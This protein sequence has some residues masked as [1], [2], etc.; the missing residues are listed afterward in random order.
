MN[1]RT[2][3]TTAMALLALAALLT[4]GTVS[5]A[6]GN[7][8][9]QGD[10][11]QQQ[12]TIEALIA[13]RFTQTAAVQQSSGA[14]LTAEAATL[15]APTL[16]AQFEATVEAAFNQALTATAGPQ[17]TATAQAEAQVRDQ[18]IAWESGIA[19]AVIA[20]ISGVLTARQADVVALAA[21]GRE[22]FTSVLDL[23][24]SDAAFADR[25]AAAEV[26]LVEA[27]NRNAAVDE[28][29]IYN[30]AGNVIAASQP[31]RL[32]AS[33]ADLPFMMDTFAASRVNP[34]FHD[35]DT[36]APILLVTEPIVSGD[37]M[38]LGV[39]AARVN[40]ALLD[41]I[42]VQA[43]QDADQPVSI[44]AVSAAES[45]LVAPVSFAGLDD[46]A[47]LS[48]EGIGLGVS[49]QSGSGTYMNFE[50]PPQTVVG[51]IRYVP[52]LGAALLV[53]VLRDDAPQVVMSLPAPTSQPS[54]TPA[55]LVPTATPRPAGF[56]TDTVAEV[57]IAEQV[58]EHGRMFWIRHTRQVWVM[59]DDPDP[60]Y[61]GGDWYCFNDTYQEGDP[62]IDPDLVPP[63][64]LLQPRR[65]FGKLW[66]EHAELK[67]NMGWAIT[68]EFELTSRYTYIA[69]GYVDDSGTYVPGPGEHRL[70]TLYNES[71][72]FFEREI[73][74]DCLGG[75]WRQT[76][77]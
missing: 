40:M 35:E 1:K 70:V 4:A 42:L 19:D 43:R 8:P 18:V 2:A 65:G 68:P 26:L 59:V 13:E 50:T 15:F 57:A 69:G 56:P 29:F 32:G 10:A 63:E 67:D 75:T 25:K 72:S 48:G 38:A 23:S 64:G 76:G 60:A 39:L 46:Y 11:T 12:Q 14:T 44:Y 37:G 73:R 5:I 21:S 62:E 27:A 74:G 30:A 24:T 20:Q 52:S 54:A 53:E 7:P 22:T 51:V 77:Q 9:A 66:R 3:M 34:I 58:F 36:G 71:I 55:G 47:V 31:E 45:R 41:A 61:P 28:L 6:L 17:A 49:G 16:T 33:I